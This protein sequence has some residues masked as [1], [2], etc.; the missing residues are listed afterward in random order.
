MQQFVPSQIREFMDTRFP[1]AK[2][3]C[4][5]GPASDVSPDYGGALSR[6]LFM[7]DRVPDH[8]M[9]LRGE[10]DAEFG[11]SI[12]TVRMVVDSW[13]TR[14]RTQA[15]K[16]LVGRNGWSP[17]AFI[18]KHLESLR[19]EGPR[20]GTASLDFVQDPLLRDTLLT[21]LGSAKDEFDRGAWKAATV[22]AGSVAEA[23]LLNA[24]SAQP[25]EAHRAARETQLSVNSDLLRW[26]L[27]QLTVAAERLNVID[28]T[29]AQQCKI[30][31]NFRNLI[32][33]GRALRLS[34]KCDRGTAHAAAAA[35]EFV[36]RNLQEQ[37]EKPTP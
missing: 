32:H 22:L 7:L 8:L 23:L 34:L 28:E 11:E 15:V 13:R 19:D 10:A 3:Q 6:L 17:L 37:A 35:V 27:H 20:P 9:S 16:P 29:T 36:I 1:F 18:R 2:G 4:E 14:N 30:A 25:E 31:K 12:E 26:D 33:P 24:L 5:G 21:D